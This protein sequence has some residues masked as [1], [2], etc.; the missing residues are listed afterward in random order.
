M[1]AGS[2]GLKFVRNQFFSHVMGIEINPPTLLVRERSATG[3]SSNSKAVPPAECADDNS[4]E[5]AQWPL[6]GSSCLHTG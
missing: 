2:V 1:I 5:G 6:G 4:G 3:R